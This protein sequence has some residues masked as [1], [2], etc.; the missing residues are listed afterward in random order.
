M[1]HKNIT[2]AHF[3]KFKDVINSCLGSYM[4]DKD[5]ISTIQDASLDD[6]NDYYV[7]PS[8]SPV[9]LD[10]IKLDEITNYRKHLITSEEN[11]SELCGVDAVCINEQNEWF[12]IEFKNCDIKNNANARK[13]IRRKMIESIWYIFFL[14]SVS[15]ENMASL[16]PGDITEFARE[17][18]NYVIVGSQAKNLHYQINI[19]AAESV[20]KHYTPPGFEQFKGYYF[21][22]VYM[23]TEIELKDFILNFKA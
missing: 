14:Y 16:F 2:N 5:I 22:D 13:S 9:N 8:T 6:N 4:K 21:K 11:F 18:I 7:Y 15:G 17:N 19:H 1:I 10:V 20:G 3:I 12:L 23:L